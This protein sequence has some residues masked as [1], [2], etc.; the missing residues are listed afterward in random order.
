MKIK[1]LDDLNLLG[2]NP[3]ITSAPKSREQISASK[4][5]NLIH[6]YDQFKLFNNDRIRFFNHLTLKKELNR[7]EDF[8]TKKTPT[9]YTLSWR[10]MDHLDKVLSLIDK[11]KVEIS[12]LESYFA[13]LKSGAPTIT[14]EQKLAIVQRLSSH[15][16]ELHN[17]T[18]ELA[19]HRVHD[20]NEDAHTMLTEHTEHH[21]NTNDFI[22]LQN[23]QDPI[24]ITLIVKN[25]AKIINT[26]PRLCAA[27]DRPQISNNPVFNHY[28]HIDENLHLG[29]DTEKMLEHAALAQTLYAGHLHENLA[30][31]APH[32]ENPSSRTWKSMSIPDALMN[33]INAAFPNLTMLDDGRMCDF[34]SGLAVQIFSNEEKKRIA[35]AFGGTTSGA[36]KGQ[37]L[38]RIFGNF[39]IMIQQWRTNLA[40]LSLMSNAIPSS[41]HQASELTQLMLQHLKNDPHKKSWNIVNTGH[42]KGGGEAAYAAAINGVYATCFGTPELSGALLNAIGPLKLAMSSKKIRHFFVKGDIVPHVSGLLTPVISQKFA[43]IGTGFWMNPSHMVGQGPL[44]K[45]WCHDLF[46]DSAITEAIRQ[47]SS[48]NAHQNAMSNLSKSNNIN[49]KEHVLNTHTIRSVIPPKSENIQKKSLYALLDDPTV[50]STYHPFQ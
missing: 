19:Q 41:Y 49:T 15:H 28:T 7:V 1:Q 6:F 39:S 50:I 34:Y 20:A 22:E 2:A 21:A 18:S 36:Q 40:G 10:Q 4:L 9:H 25:C 47:K 8:A 11:T 26:L 35:L 38:A 5:T 37:I 12:Q 29:D 48:K 30:Q 17:L 43:H 32:F 16:A 31:C 3:T 44:K 13:N 23:I 24:F 46:F 27:M 42:S 45:F 14:P 33:K